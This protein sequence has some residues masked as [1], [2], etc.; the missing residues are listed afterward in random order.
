[1]YHIHKYHCEYMSFLSHIVHMGDTLGTVGTSEA[2]TIFN[3]SKQCYCTTSSYGISK[4]LYAAT[5]VTCIIPQMGSVTYKPLNYY[6]ILS[7]VK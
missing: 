7:Y 3:H 1:M 6:V 2:R 4:K 5:L